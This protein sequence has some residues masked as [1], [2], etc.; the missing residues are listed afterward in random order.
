MEA[1]AKAQPGQAPVPAGGRMVVVGDSDFLSNAYVGL[2]GNSD[3]LLNIVQWLTKDER[4]ISIPVKETKF[5]VLL[6]TQHQR[7]LMLLFNIAILPLIFFLMGGL[8]LM[9][10]RRFSS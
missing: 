8:R 9:L 1:A 2:S 4:F 3:F 7:F 10:R 6:L 5:K